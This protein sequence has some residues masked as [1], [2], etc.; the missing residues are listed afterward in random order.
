[1]YWKRRECRTVI[2]YTNAG[3]AQSGDYNTAIRYFYIKLAVAM[4]SR[5]KQK[6]LGFLLFN[7]SISY[8]MIPRLYTM[9]C[10]Q[11]IVQLCWMYSY[12]RTVPSTTAPLINFQPIT[13]R[14]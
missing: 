4:H 2:D 9:P 6:L 3:R 12:K 8:N 5:A 7:H 14:A 1:M 10:P 11:S 13:A